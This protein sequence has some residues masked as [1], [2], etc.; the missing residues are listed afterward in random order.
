MRLGVEHVSPDHTWPALNFGWTLADVI[1]SG[2]K[3]VNEN[4]ETN[5]NKGKKFE[6]VKKNS[7][8]K[9]EEMGEFGEWSTEMM[10]EEVST[11]V[12]WCPGVQ[13]YRCPGRYDLGGQ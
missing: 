13:V 4:K 6:P 1:N 11:G 9:D 10:D 5:A 3:E 8:N 2:K 12:L 7:D